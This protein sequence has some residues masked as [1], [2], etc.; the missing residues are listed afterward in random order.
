MKAFNKECCFLWNPREYIIRKTNPGLRGA[1]QANGTTAIAPGFVYD[2]N[3]RPVVTGVTATAADNA[4]RNKPVEFSVHWGS[5]RFPQQAA[6]DG[7]TNWFSEDALGISSFREGAGQMESA[8]TT[9]KVLVQLIPK[10]S[11]CRKLSNMITR[12]NTTGKTK[13]TEH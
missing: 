6:K 1:V 9:R 4:L 8:N 12:N 2:A 7:E 11:S 10:V 3:G 13:I 5:K